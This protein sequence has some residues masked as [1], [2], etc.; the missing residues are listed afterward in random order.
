MRGRKKGEDKPARLLGGLFEKYK[1]ILKAPEASV[2][3]EFRVVVDELIGIKLKQEQITYKP[4][5]R[6]IYLKTPA[7]VRSEI[8]LH[9]EEIITHLKARLGVSQAPLDVL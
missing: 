5:S 3:N 7:P 9:K 8:K 2:T 6:I 1:K 4:A